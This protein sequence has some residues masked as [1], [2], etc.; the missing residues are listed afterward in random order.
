MNDDLEQLPRNL[1]LDKIAE[2]LDE[3]LKRV[4]QKQP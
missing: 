4:Q 2:I 3:E 1:R